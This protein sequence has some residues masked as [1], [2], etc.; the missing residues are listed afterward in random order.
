MPEIAG[1]L[2]AFDA[3]ESWTACVAAGAR[4]M[5]NASDSSGLRA[6]RERR[7]TQICRHLQF[8]KESSRRQRAD[9]RQG[10]E[11]RR[12][13]LPKQWLFAAGGRRR[14][15]RP[16]SAS[17]CAA[18]GSVST[19]TI[20]SADSTPSSAR[21]RRAARQQRRDAP[22]GRCCAPAPIARS[23]TPSF[24]T[25]TALDGAGFQFVIGPEHDWIIIEDKIATEDFLRL[26]FRNGRADA[27]QHHRSP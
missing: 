13:H 2:A 16:S 17:L 3:R 4:A 27:Q 26:R 5:P 19:T 22:A 8:S 7:S 12:A 14:R 21:P 9:V 1:F 25:S 15:T 23:A 20:P 24:S 18:T 11:S 6:R 10:H